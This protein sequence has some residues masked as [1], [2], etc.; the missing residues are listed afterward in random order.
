MDFF[1]ADTIA[2]NSLTLMAITNEI[3][4]NRNQHFYGF[5]CTPE[6]KGG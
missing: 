1:L 5:L 2:D 6:C 4:G 3:S